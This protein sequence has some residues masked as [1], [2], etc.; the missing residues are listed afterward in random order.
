MLTVD[1]CL[2]IHLPRCIVT[3]FTQEII[4]KIT[5][6]KASVL[7]QQIQDAIKGITLVAR[8]SLNEFQDPVK[9]L[10]LAKQDLQDKLAKTV[11]LS[12]YLAIIRG[13]IGV[14]NVTS[15]VHTK[16]AELSATEKMIIRYVELVADT[17]KA[18]DI[19]VVQGKVSKLR[20]SDKS[21]YYGAQ[22][23]ETGLLSNKDIDQFEIVLRDLRKM[24]QTLN[25]QILELNIR[26]EIE[27]KTDIV[28]FLEAEKII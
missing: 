5:L 11:M 1:Y 22:Q 13:Q 6:R 8:V 21:T 23:V 24:K 17:N 9:A 25:D 19:V 3:Y 26:T 4:M 20:T 18:E 10:A 15:G 14:A 2:V 16:L 27:I 7:Q 28:T 12:D